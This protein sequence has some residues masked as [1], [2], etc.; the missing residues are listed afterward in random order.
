MRLA[1]NYFRKKSFVHDSKWSS[2]IYNTSTRH[3]RHEYDTSNTNVTWVQHKC[4]MGARWKTRVRHECYTNA[5]SATR[6]KK[7]WFLVTT[8]VKTYFHVPICT[9]WQVKD[10]KDRNNFILSTTF[11]KASFPCKSTFVKCTTKTEFCNGKSYVK[12]LYTTL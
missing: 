1:F 8:R 4:D 12:T 9:I 11:G 5:T 3:E 2:L 6:M 7:F 10:C